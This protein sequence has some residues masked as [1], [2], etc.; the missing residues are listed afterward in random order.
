[1][2]QMGPELAE[3]AI[4][5]KRLSLSNLAGDPALAD[6]AGHRLKTVSLRTL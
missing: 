1:M 2:S 3:P 4:V 6:A 5:A